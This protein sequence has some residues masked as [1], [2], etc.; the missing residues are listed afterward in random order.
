M[1]SRCAKKRLLEVLSSPLSDV[2]VDP[3]PIIRVVEDH[4]G[5]SSAGGSM[6]TK[7]VRSATDPEQVLAVEG[8]K[9]R[10]I[11]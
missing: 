3:V 8:A 1:F 6:E 7:G 11:R 5:Q 9:R 10:H 4:A 2:F